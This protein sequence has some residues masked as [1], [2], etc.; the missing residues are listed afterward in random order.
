MR[1]SGSTCSRILAAMLRSTLPRALAGC[2]AQAGC[3]FSAASSARSTSCW[4]LS[5]TL[6]IVAP[7]DGLSLRNSIGSR[8]RDKFTVDE[9]HVLIH[10]VS[11][12]SLFF[13]DLLGRANCANPFRYLIGAE[14][15]PEQRRLRETTAAQLPRCFHPSPLPRATTPRSLGE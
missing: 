1:A 10:G 15:A 14:A 7:V 5:G 13:L 4:V 6:Q 12:F 11:L 9:V 3:A 8:R 2:F